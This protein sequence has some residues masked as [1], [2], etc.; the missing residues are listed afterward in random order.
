MIGP[1]ADGPDLTIGCFARAELSAVPCD[2]TGIATR[3]ERLAYASRLGRA[4][5]RGRWRIFYASG[6]GPVAGVQCD[7]VGGWSSSPKQ[8]G[9]YASAF[10]RGDL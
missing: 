7:V 4:A 10:R 8:M 1:E 9:D 6:L 5:G 2:A 3:A